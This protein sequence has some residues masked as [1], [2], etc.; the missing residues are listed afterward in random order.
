MKGIDLRALMEE[1]PADWQ[2]QDEDGTAAFWMPAKYNRGNVWAGTLV[3]RSAWERHPDSDELIHVIEGEVEI[4]M[5]TEEDRVTETLHAGCVLVVPRGIW[6]RHDARE[7]VKEWGV[8]VGRSEHSS[9]EDPRP[10]P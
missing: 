4:T 1:Q 6:H 5:L 10:T 2:D 7:Q 3:G 8:S 9:A